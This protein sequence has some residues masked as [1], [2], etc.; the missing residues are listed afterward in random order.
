MRP[1]VECD[2]KVMTFTTSGQKF[3][4]LFVDRVGD[5]PISVFHLPPY[6]GYSLTTSQ[7][8][9]EM[10][11]PYDACY[12]TEENGSY[13]LPLLWWENPLKLSCPVQLPTPAPSPPLPA[14]SLSCFPYGM[15]V[16][17]QVQEKDIQILTVTVSGDWVP[18][19]SELC[20]YRVDSHN[21]TFAISLSAACINKEDDS[22]LLRMKLDDREYNLSCPV[23]GQFPNT[24][25]WYSPQFPGVPQL[26][27]IPVPASPTP[28]SPPPPH[29]PSQEQIKQHY[30][31]PGFQYPW[32]P[33]VYPPGSQPPGPPQPIPGSPPGPQQQ[34]QQLSNPTGPEKSPDSLQY[35]VP[36]D[37]SQYPVFYY[38][39]LTP[40]PTTAAPQTI[41]TTPVPSSVEPPKPPDSQYYPQYYFQIPYYPAPT[42]APV[43]HTPAPLP[44]PKQ[45]VAPQFQ[46]EPFS[47]VG[48]SSYYPYWPVFYYSMTAPHQS[49]PTDT[50]NIPSYQ[51]PYVI[52]PTHQPPAEEQPQRPVDPQSAC[53]SSTHTFGGYYFYP[54]YPYH[55]AL[56]PTP[57]P[58]VPQYPDIQIPLTTEMP[59]STTT[60]VM[61]TTTITTPDTATETTTT[62]AM[63]PTETST[64]T[65]TRRFTTKASKPTPQSPHL[66]CLKDRMF[67]LLPSA[68]PESIQVR[69]KKTWR[70][71][72]NVAPHC[73][74]T[75]QRTDHSE[76]IL[77]SPLPACHSQL[78]T[79]TTISLPV[80][81][82]DVSMAQYRTLDLQCPYQSTTESPATVT[83]PASTTPPSTTKA[84]T[85][86]PVDT[87]TKVICSTHQM[88]V[89]LPAGPISGIVV[90]DIKGKKMKLQEAPK[91]CGYS[92]SK[93]KNGKVRLSL[94]LNSYCHMTMQA[95]IDSYFTLSS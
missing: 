34:Q 36:F 64:T 54:Y 71:L 80:R 51:P 42:A 48:Y 87:K 50:S 6:C 13:V 5:P 61:S 69:D 95:S 49:P 21:L 39:P 77:H 9:L 17:I 63:S 23:S 53:S 26:P 30:L 24:P 12:I 82:W 86:S 74:Y 89:E 76:I 72:S 37:N 70:Y 28:T 94:Q 78:Q 60:S 91:H 81:F 58:L 68:H 90:K 93:G 52:L 16:Q 45:P 56:Y 55:H 4:H 29:L 79:P 7:Q 2:D 35:Q 40:A 84:K 73:G 20:A 11:V 62:I 41:S 18:F 3:T 19:V 8:D 32:L 67:A 44:P 25:S 1:L 22:L 31:F 66:Q 83:P 85:S 43:T 38:P 65:S 10:M 14:P 92:A 46:T 59:S 75:L 57:Y 33:Q 47:P 27:D 15:M 88:T